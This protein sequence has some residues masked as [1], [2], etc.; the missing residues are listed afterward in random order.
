MTDN[1]TEIDI[2]SAQLAE[3]ARQYQEDTTREE[4]RNIENKILAETVWKPSPA[5]QEDVLALNEAQIERIYEDL[6][7]D[8]KEAKRILRS[9]YL[10]RL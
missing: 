6:P 5:E 10:D 9:Y 2:D 3:Y 4:R 8:A 1:I 7:D